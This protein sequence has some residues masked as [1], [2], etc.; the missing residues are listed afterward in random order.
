[1]AEKWVAKRCKAQN[2][3]VITID[4]CSCAWAVSEMSKTGAN[5]RGSG[6]QCAHPCPIAWARERLRKPPYVGS[7]RFW[8]RGVEA[9]YWIRCSTDLAISV[10]VQVRF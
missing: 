8:I 2:G 7:Y 10:M 6:V 5:A 9:V 4:L 1:M 3:E